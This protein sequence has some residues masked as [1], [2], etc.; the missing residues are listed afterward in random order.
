MY[1][2]LCKKNGEQIR[3]RSISVNARVVD[4]AAQLVFTKTYSNVGEEFAD[5]QSGNATFKAY[6]NTS[7][8]VLTGFEIKLDGKKITA[9]VTN[10]SEAMRQFD[11]HTASNI[12]KE[13]GIE[14]NNLDPYIQEDFFLCRLNNLSL[15]K[16][17]EVIITYVTEMSM[18]EEHLLLVLPTSLSTVRSSQYFET[19]PSHS[20]SNTTDDEST[21]TT[22]T[23]AEESQ[24]ISIKLELEMQ[25]NIVEICSPSHPS[26]IEA[27][28]K[29]STGKVVYTDTRSID[30]VNQ[31]DMIVLVKL[32]DPHVPCGF[33]EQDSEGSRALMIVFY[34]K[35]NEKEAPKK[36]FAEAIADASKPVVTPRNK[37]E[38][39]LIFLVDCSESMVG[40]NIKHAKSSLYLFAGSLEQG[41]YFNIISFGSK[42]H[43]LFPQSVQYSEKHLEEAKKYIHTLKAESGETNLLAPLQDIYKTPATT[44]PRKI[45]LL[46]DG[47]VTDIGQIV[48]LVRE[49]ANTTSVFPIGMGEFVSRQLV[50]LVANAG[51]GVAELALENDPIEKKVMRQIKRALQPAYTN[52]RID[53]GSMPSQKQ[54]PRDLRTLFDGDRLTVFN[55]LGK[56]EAING[57]V[58]LLANGPNGPVSFPVLI[59]SDHVKQGDMIHCLAAYTMIQDLQDKL[60]DT[61]D[62]KESERLE[63]LVID[64]GIKYGLATNYTSFLSVE[65]K[66]VSANKNQFEN[67]M[68]SLRGSA[69][70]IP[71]NHHHAPHHPVAST[72]ATATPTTASATSG[73]ASSSPIK[74]LSSTAPT[75]TPTITSMSANA[76][77]F[78]P[79]TPLSKS[80]LRFNSPEFVPKSLQSSI[81]SIPFK[82]AAA[83]VVATPAPA[84][85]TVVVA[86]T[87]AAPVSVAPVPTPAADTTPVAAPVTPTKPA[88]TTPAEPSSPATKVSPVKETVAPVETATPAPAQATPTPAPVT[89]VKATPAP[90]QPSTPVSD[91]A[92][93]KIMSA[94]QAG[95]SQMGMSSPA[96]AAGASSTMTSAPGFA[97]AAAA[98]ASS[99]NVSAAAAAAAS[100]TA[101]KKQYSI[102]FLL[103]QRY[104][105]PNT[106]IPE[107]L[108]QHQ[109]L[110][111]PQ[112]KGIFKGDSRRGGKDRHHHERPAQ[113]AAAPVKKIILKDTEGEHSETFKQFKFNLNRITMETYAQLIKTIEEIVIPNEEALK[114]IAKI[115]FEKAIIDQKYSAVYAIMTGHLDV[116]YPKY[117]TVTLKRQVILNCQSVFEEKLDRSKHEELSKEDREEEEFIFK[118][119]NLGNIKFIGEL[120]KH[121]VLAEGVVQAC[122]RML[123]KQ[124]EETFNEEIIESMIKLITTIGKKM[125]HDDESEEQSK[126]EKKKAFMV[127]VFSKLLSLSENSNVTSR[128]SYLIMGLLD[129]RKGGWEP[130]TTGLLKV[131]K[132]DHE[133]EERFIKQHGSGRRD[134]RRDDRRGDDRRG[135]GDRRD[136]RRGGDR[137]GDRDTPRK[138][139]FG[140]KGSKDGWETVGKST[141]KGK[142]T[143]KK[144]ELNNSGTTP[145]KSGSTPSPLRTST[146]GTKAAANTSQRNMYNLLNADNEDDYEAPNDSPLRDEKASSTS[147]S[148]SSTSKKAEPEISI[149]K[150]EDNIAMTLDEYVE[151]GDVDEA[152]ECIKELNYPTL[153]GKIV[154]II[155]N[156][157]F[158]KKE[159]ERKLVV[160]LFNNIVINQMFTTENLKDGFN[161]CLETIEE[162]EI[163]LPGASKFL[164]EIIGI[165]IELDI[166]TLNYLEEA[167]INLVDEGKAEEMLKDTL[168]AIEK[169]SDQERLIELYESAENL[170]IL[171][172]F[173]PKNRTNQYLQ[174][175][176]FQKFIPYLSSSSK[177]VSAEQSEPSLSQYLVMQQKADG[178]W[179]LNKSLAGVLGIALSDLESSEHSDMLARTHPKIWATCLA[180]SFIKIT[181]TEEEEELE[182]I[183]QKAETWLSEEYE[184]SE[185]PQQTLS[186]VLK[187]ATRLIS[188]FN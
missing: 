61:T 66:P 24:G 9:E 56:D 127:S 30:V 159:K 22:A 123:L 58:K 31:S 175:E 8:G 138:G 34:P 162:V 16:E 38:M 113:P 108:K 129:L 39:E 154:C 90:A 98:A 55:I 63:K 128:A 68:I 103:D 60:E 100:P 17:L 14:E 64:L 73:S 3:P 44:R 70:G 147:T 187:K 32:E 7:I 149:E 99:S 148:T 72:T 150:L 178:Y 80:T 152:I 82:P 43:K 176:F 69:S 125:D 124:A 131:N 88:V 67:A 155:L 109:S 74:P 174:E 102:S 137:G 163:D 97:A 12:V 170:D 65:D 110:L 107:R 23:S 4:L 184:K 179:E 33:I 26:G 121:S 135:G 177:V 95:L 89:P 37:Q 119:R 83:S 146:S 20:L 78:T 93:N 114:G 47:R 10:L 111:N 158:E 133:K 167:Y 188:E 54:A 62:K 164:A 2:A 130:K 136:D 105:E 25:S 51:C 118:R 126:R 48:D 168:L 139:L 6:L 157:S 71:T 151:S 101:G 11:S 171:K 182:L 115:L 36:S 153:F 161:E 122:I 142:Q 1:S 57:T 27:K 59:K 85:A 50:D 42:F 46:T 144:N 19:L 145:L 117:D 180:L 183:K 15:H 169:H 181:L 84:P 165:C 86:P 172:I 18:Q 186:E 92:S 21:T 134:D 140:G 40:Y 76:P 53:W 106:R 49:N 5:D 52:I 160:D 116:K 35:L 185:A 112:Q 132:E 75:F 81:G 28:W 104:I 94:I 13:A 41:T 173:R 77:T 143:P 141:P 29:E 91:T 120:Y 79:S 156:K 45:F 87:P 96:A 166:L